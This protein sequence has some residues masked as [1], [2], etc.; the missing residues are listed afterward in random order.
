MVKTHSLRRARRGVDFE[1]SFVDLADAAARCQLAAEVYRTMYDNTETFTVIDIDLLYLLG[2]I[3]EGISKGCQFSHGSRIVELLK[4]YMPGSRV[5][6][7]I[8]LF[9]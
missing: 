5:W 8:E 9:P 1:G 3:T 7:Y 2:S 6:D 4:E